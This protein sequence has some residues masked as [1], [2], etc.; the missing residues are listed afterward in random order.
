MRI[1]R[2]FPRKTND[3]CDD[4]L[5]LTKGIDGCTR[6]GIDVAETQPFPEKT[7]FSAILLLVGIIGFPIGGRTAHLDT[8]L[9]AFGYVLVPAA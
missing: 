2:F 9:A 6:D 4:G 5:Q 7:D 3:L 1:Y 8:F